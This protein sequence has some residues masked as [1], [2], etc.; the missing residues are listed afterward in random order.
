VTHWFDFDNLFTGLS[1]REKVKLIINFIHP[2]ANTLLINSLD[3]VAWVFN[4]R[5]SDFPF[6]PLF[7]SYAILT[8]QSIK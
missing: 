6:S 7:K 8:N 2:R 3:D 4:L 5:G 1:W